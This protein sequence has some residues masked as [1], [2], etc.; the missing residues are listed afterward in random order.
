MIAR[1]EKADLGCSRRSIT[2]ADVGEVDM[3]EA[4]TC[5]ILE[6]CCQQRCVLSVHVFHPFQILTSHVAQSAADS[7][8]AEKIT[9]T[10]AQQIDSNLDV[11]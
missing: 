8:I 5:N 1:Y 2:A 7:S 11:R 6:R 9:D 10:P 3:G 4:T